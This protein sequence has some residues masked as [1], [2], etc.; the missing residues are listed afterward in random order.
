M[1]PGVESVTPILAPWKI[2]SREFQKQDSVI[3]VGGVS[4][5]GDRVVVMA[6][7]CAVEKLEITVGIAKSVAQSGARILR[8]VPINPGPHPIRFRAGSRRIRIFGGGQK[9][10]R[11]ACGK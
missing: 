9:R 1:F 5:G 8:V 10:N 4:V 2:V 11:I 3:D 7:P 6:G